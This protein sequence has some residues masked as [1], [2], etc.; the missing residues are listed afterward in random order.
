MSFF[1][2]LYFTIYHINREARLR[3]YD[4]LSVILGGLKSVLISFFETILAQEEG[5]DYDVLFELDTG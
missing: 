4:A 5:L 1:V 3:Y 2:A